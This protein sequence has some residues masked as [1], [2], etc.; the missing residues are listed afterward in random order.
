LRRIF[1]QDCM[2]KNVGA[3]GYGEAFSPARLEK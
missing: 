1:L 3:A 2:R